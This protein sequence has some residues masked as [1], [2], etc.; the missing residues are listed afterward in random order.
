MERVRIEER[1]TE[2]KKKIG[3]NYCAHIIPD[4]SDHSMS[5][6]NIYPYRFDNGKIYEKFLLYCEAR[7]PV[8]G[9]DIV[10]IAL[11]K[12]I[13]LTRALS[14]RASQPARVCCIATMGDFLV[15]R[16]ICCGV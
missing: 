10:R 12:S 6:V 8:C 14:L 3:S 2:K 9:A 1:K 13:L 4:S 16:N 5:K 11:R 7:H 15:R